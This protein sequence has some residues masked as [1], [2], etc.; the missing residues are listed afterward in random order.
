MDTT[1]DKDTVSAATPSTTKLAEMIK[2]LSATVEKLSSEV[3]ATSD[4][5][6]AKRHRSASDLDDSDG[7]E[8]Q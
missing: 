5:P 3:S 1:K 2:T 7:E 4:E 6:P 8:E